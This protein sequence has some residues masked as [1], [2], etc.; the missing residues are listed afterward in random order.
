MICPNCGAQV[1][2]EALRCPACHADL[3]KTMVIPKLEGRWCEN[4]GALI[5]QGADTCP[6]CGFPAP[7]PPA[8]MV[9]REARKAL[10]VSTVYMAPSAS[11]RKAGE[12]AGP[13]QAPAPAAGTSSDGP[14][15]V[16][17]TGARH[18]LPLMGEES[19]PEDTHAIVRIE[20]AIPSEPVPGQPE[21]ERDHGPRLRTFLV[22][23]VAAVAVVG[24]GALLITHPW[25]PSASDPRAKTEADT[26]MAGFPGVVETLNG[27]D[28]TKSPDSSEEIQSGDQITYQKL[29]D[30]YAQLGKINDRATACEEA[31]LSTA[32][33][34]DEAARASAKAE[35]DQVSLDLSNL[36]SSIGDIDVTSGTYAQEAQDMTTLG[37]YLRNRTDAIDTAWDEAL[38]VTDPASQEE[39]VLAYL[40]E[41]DADSWQAQFE[42]A[43]PTLAPQE[44]DGR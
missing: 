11:A 40:T 16:S 13:S 27:Q 24:G 14:V 38:K 41:S 3:G 4:C 7:Q 12:D 15:P 5:P 35:A 21:S 29:Q 9:G 1:S 10:S 17:P 43:Y 37:N 30:V 42:Q 32:A 18:A 23:L 44:K 20:S 19:S 36:I 8:H 34:A 31:Y 26:S 22:A 6:G 39:R 2:D 33:S 25:N 28:E